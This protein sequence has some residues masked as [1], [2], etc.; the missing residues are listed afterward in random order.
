[1]S[2]NQETAKTPSMWVVVPLIAQT[3]GIVALLVAAFWAGG[4]FRGF[5]AQQ[6]LANM[7][8]ERNRSDI[9]LLTATSLRQTQQIAVLITENQATRRDLD[10]LLTALQ[11]HTP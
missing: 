11:S 5:A 6:Q 3:I 8:I 2:Q 4:E 1:M 9:D 7:N 10:R